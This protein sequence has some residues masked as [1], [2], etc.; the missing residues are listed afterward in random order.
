MSIG[1]GT[2]HAMLPSLRGDAD[3]S[4]RSF[5]EPEFDEAME[6]L[7]ASRKLR[8]SRLV[9][10]AKNLAGGRVS[11]AKGALSELLAQ[12]PHNPDALN[13]MAEIAGREGQHR[14]AEFLLARC[15]QA[16]PGIG[17]YRY[18]HVLA[19][20]K[21]GR[22]DGALAETD[23]LLK[24]EPSNLVVRDSQ[25]SL[26]KKMGNYAGAAVC[27][28]ALAGDYPRSSYIWN[29]LGA[30]LR[31]LGAHRE[32]CTDAF[33]KAA[34]LNPSRGRT[35][36]NLASLGTFRFSDS[37]IARMEAAL[38]GPAI[39]A[40]NRADLHYALGK[41]YDDAK[42]YGKAFE[43]YARGNAIRRVGFDYD[44]DST[45][46]MVAQTEAVFTPEVFGK[47]GGAGYPARDPIFVVGMQRAGSTLIEQ[48]LGSHSQVEAL[49]ELNFLGKLAVDEIG[50]KTGARYPR[51]L[52][53]LGA[54]ELRAIGEKYLS[55]ARLKRSTVKPFFVDKNPYNFWHVGLIRLILPNARIIDAR[56]HPMACCFANF[57]KS[58]A[59][60][61]P[62]SY[63]QTEIGRFY[64][65]YV[66]LMAHFDRVQP[67][68]LHRVIYERLV[69][70]LESEVRRMLEYL[71]LP[72]E[73]SC[74]EYYRNDRSFNSLSSEQVRSPIF[75]EGVDRWRNY[76]AW[77]GPL[78]LVLGSV[79]DTW[80]DVPSEFH[81]RQ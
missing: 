67:G 26:L 81:P 59:F 75:S 53:K 71:E 1:A 62:L 32:E 22:L 20:E 21:L 54:A 15:V 5:A 64:L 57:T 43:N 17:Y 16:S 2:M 23:A 37:H 50:P 70:D 61:P 4:Y 72:F 10:I 51:G 25:A 58:F 73:Q 39:S 38:S 68:K 66:R 31:D 36:W 55:F 11:A 8:D 42:N 69:A 19:L 74:L 6:A 28:R 49:G 60:G 76:E 52:D 7:R 80:P 47:L 44:P 9:A 35:W 79:L 56:R 48:I 29:Q 30:A 27:Y 14:E 45:S 34:E 46:A 33:L 65:D 77:L 41:A 63:K 12:S 40:G 24:S 3:L 78:K 13:L 18:N